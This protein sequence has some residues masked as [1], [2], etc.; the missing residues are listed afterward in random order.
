MSLK[1]ELIKIYNSP[2]M[3]SGGV[4]PSW[5]KPTYAD[6]MALVNDTE[7]MMKLLKKQK[8]T[9]EIR[10][11]DNFHQHADAKN[12]TINSHKK[13]KYYPYY[14][15]KRDEKPI[16]KLDFRYDDVNKPWVYYQREFTTGTVN[17]S[18]PK[19]RYDRRIQPTKYL[20]ADA[21][22][23][24]IFEMGMYDVNKVM[25]YAE[26][27]RR[28]IIKPTPA[29]VKKATNTSSPTKPKTS[30][31]I[32]NPYIDYLAPRTMNL[33]AG[34]NAPQTFLP[35]AGANLNTTTASLPVIS[36]TNSLN[37]SNTIPA[38]VKMK[39]GVPV[40]IS[41]KERDY[42]TQQPAQNIKTIRTGER[43]DAKFQTGGN[44]EPEYEA[45]HN[46]VVLKSNPND[47]IKM[48]GSGE[49]VDESRYAATINGDHHSEDTDKDGNTGELMSG[50]EYILSDVKDLDYNDVS[51]KSKKSVAALARPIVEKI[52]E[53]EQSKDKYNLN[54][55]PIYVQK[56]EQMK[57]RFD[58]AKKTDELISTFVSAT[59]P[60]PQRASAV[61][62]HLM[63]GI[64]SGEISIEDIQQSMAAMSNN[65]QN[66]ASNQSSSLGNTI[67]PAMGFGGP[68]INIRNY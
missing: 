1:E 67:N 28:G 9:S 58:N 5:P 51:R 11:I 60:N 53:L 40:P 68:R 6:S 57:S 14:N 44:T 48:F 61:K 8:Y 18:L 7:N 59:E 27:V 38:I 13:E 16:S 55:I 29:P 43:Y 47:N 39:N 3:Q 63:A 33:N 45:E 66:P 34:T 64:K 26:K 25:P 12:K 17:E 4:N 22:G 62:N 30:T 19:V 54:L 20:S 42:I 41:E 2:Q 50:G 65:Q 21:L 46:E 31:I 37:N 35:T 49:L 52:S 24:D 56:L 15:E 32:S 36:R 10:T 23:G